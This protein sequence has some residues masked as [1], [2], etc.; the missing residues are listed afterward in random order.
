MSLHVSQNWSNGEDW[1]RIFTKKYSPLAR[2]ELAKNLRLKR[3]NASSQWEGVFGVR[4]RF[5]QRFREQEI[6]FESERETRSVENISKCRGVIFVHGIPLWQ[7]W[8]TQMNNLVLETWNLGIVQRIENVLKHSPSISCS[9]V[10]FN[11]WRKIYGFEHKDN[12]TYYPF[13]VVVSSWIVLSVHNRD[14]GTVALSLTARHRKYDR[15]EP[16]TAIQPKIAAQLEHA[17]EWPFSRDY[18]RDFVAKHGHIDW[19]EGWHGYKYNEIIVWEPGVSAFFVDDDHLFHES[20]SWAMSEFVDIKLQQ[21]WAEYHYGSR[22]VKIK[23][24][25][26]LYP[27]LELYI[28]KDWVTKKN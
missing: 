5:N 16:D 10:K 14:A 13:G 20:M 7:E 21:Q 19:Q 23:K 24:I 27:Q 18:M 1:V 2:T 12:P 3:S 26:S 8:N 6:K 9:T 22:W 17:I 4:D 25:M 28:K 11:K 15:N